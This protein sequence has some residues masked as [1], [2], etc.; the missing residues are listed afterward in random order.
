MAMAD[1]MSDDDVIHL[2]SFNTHRSQGMYFRA[3][4]L[5][6]RTPIKKNQNAVKKSDNKELHVKALSGQNSLPTL[7]DT[8][9]VLFVLKY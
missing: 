4:L 8:L 3:D 2:A 6:A 1:G 7:S 5:N 9:V